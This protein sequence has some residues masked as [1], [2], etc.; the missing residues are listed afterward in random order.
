M[1]EEISMDVEPIHFP[2]PPGLDNPIPHPE[3]AILVQ[4][5]PIPGG[6]PI[7]DMEVDKPS[8]VYKPTHRLT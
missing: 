4:D 2:P 7:V 5:H 6:D 3:E 8:E 1:K